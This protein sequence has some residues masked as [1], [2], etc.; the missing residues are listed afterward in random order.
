MKINIL[1]RKTKA[2]AAFDIINV[3]I[4]LVICFVTIY[5]V[6]YVLIN[7][8]NDGIDAARGG[9]YF[10]TRKFS[11]QAYKTV[12]ANNDIIVSFGIT[13]AKTVI[14]TVIHVLFTAMVAYPLSKRDLVGRKVYMTIG[15]ITMFFSG[16]LIPTYLWF[17]QLGLVDNFMI[18]ILPA[19]FSFYDLVIFMA[20]FREIPSALEEAAKIDGADDFKIF[21]KVIIKVSLPVLATI[22]LFHGVYQWNDYF[23]GVM[24]VVRKNYLLPIQTYLYKIVS[25]SSAN[26]NISQQ[27]ISAA[28]RTVTSQTVKFATMIVTTLPIV[29]VYPFLQ[30]YFVK[31][32]MV[33]AVKG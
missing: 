33:G 31:G 24:Y 28:N 11:F 27:A 14:G 18:Y 25:E 6:W 3:L 15:I 10:I 21:Y 32:M 5:P 2:E 4:M 1:K 8:F 12:F 20:F 13:L 17:K 22:A 29:C 9:I 30:K 26:Q 23:T 7:S 19:M 16:G